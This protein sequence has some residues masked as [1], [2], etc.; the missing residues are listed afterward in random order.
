M[1]V[2]LK[3]KKGD[4]VLVISGDSKGKLGKI[5]EI[6]KVKGRAIVEGVNLVKKHSKPN[7]KYPQGGIVE[8]AAPIHLS[9]LK[10]SEAGKATRIGRRVEADKIVRYSKIS[11]N[12]IK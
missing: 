3:I 2:K 5:V 1:S 4:T 11:N 9:N 7:N 10:Y 12:T 6:D 8:I